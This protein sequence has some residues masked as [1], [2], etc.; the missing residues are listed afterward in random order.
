MLH[1]RFLRR[2]PMA[3][4]ETVE[5]LNKK[6]EMMKAQFDVCDKHRRLA[7]DIVAEQRQL[8]KKLE[9]ENE[10]LRANVMIL[11][12]AAGNRH[13]EQDVLTIMRL[14]AEKAELEKQL[15]ALHKPRAKNDDECAYPDS[16]FPAAKR[17]D[18]TK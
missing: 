11:E 4:R 14:T 6:I 12:T 2:I 9:Q 10:A 3:N 1:I 5:S 13:S 8:I 17:F 7:E 18:T 16:V 15:E